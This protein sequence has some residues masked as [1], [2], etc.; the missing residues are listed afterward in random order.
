MAHS[1]SLATRRY[2]IERKTKYGK[3]YGF[4]SFGR[5][6]SNKYGKKSYWILLL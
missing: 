3:R 4:S 5:N 6:L 1:V 2:P